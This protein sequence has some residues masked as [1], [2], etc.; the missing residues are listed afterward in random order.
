MALDKGFDIIMNGLEKEIFGD[1][2]LQEADGT[3]QEE[4]ERRERLAGM[5]PGLARWCHP[6][7]YGIPNELVEVSGH[8]IHI[9]YRDLMY[10]VPGLGND[11]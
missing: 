6:A 3:L 1:S 5:L 9:I 8:R 11:A 2:S 7:L 10:T 4:G